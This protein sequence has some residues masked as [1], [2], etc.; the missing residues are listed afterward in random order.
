MKNRWIP[1]L[2]ALVLLLSAC[3]EEEGGAQAQ[4]LALTVT[5][6]EA[7]DTLDPARATARGGEM[8]LH[9]LYENLL[10]WEDGGDGWAVPAPGQAEE[11]TVETDY[12][13]NATY[14]F[15]LRRD[16]AWSDGQAVTASDF[17]NAWRRLADP[18]NDLPHRTL[19]EAVAG[20]D[21]VQETGD[22]SLLA[23]SAPDEHTFVVSLSGSCAWFLEELCAGAYT[24]PVRE[25]TAPDGSVTNGPYTAVQFDPA[26]VV[27]EP[28]EHYYDRSRVGPESLQFV[29]SQGAE[30]DY[31]SFLD[32]QCQL[33][34]LLP[35]GVLEQRREE[36]GWTPEPVTALTAVLFNTRQAP[37]DNAD[38][39]LAFRLVVDTQ[40]AADAAGDAALRAAA[41]VVPYGVADYGTRPEAAEPEP[42]EGLPDP[43]AASA[44]PEQ[45]PEQTC[46]DFRAHSL[47]KVTVPA[48]NDCQADCQEARR[49][50]AGAGYPNGEGFPAVEY[51]YVDSDEGAAAAAALCAMWRQELGVTVTAR[52]LAREELDARLA[53]AKAADGPVE[54]D[55]ADEADGADGADAPEDSG[56]EDAG[57]AGAPEAAPFAMAAVDLSA[58]YSDAGALLGR[59]HSASPNN[60]SGYRSDAFDI[61]LSSAA[62]AVSA[63]VRDAYLHDAEAILLEEAPVIP[64]WCRGG[65]SLLAEGL[66]GLFRQ[67]D[68]VY[69]LF[70]VTAEGAPPQK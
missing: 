60:F 26:R 47:E 36:G 68:G 12:A 22:A 11:Y 21:E 6:G 51:L 52:G 14:T 63:E 49:L 18:A 64:L 27:L 8:I 46:W 24:M 32:G 69:F 23:V 9:H 28:N 65:G 43:N 38:V 66:G 44:A 33:L 2:L 67:P 56:G 70:S 57:E 62:A 54:A 15:T 39:R 34:T 37:F 29:Q 3:G 4:P 41:G 61:L 10:R 42:D 20:Y 53:A 19:L 45:E 7:Q 5:V 17:V 35:E 50:L 40:A 48:E 55:E 30:A 59:W 31:Q 16:A 25:G 13:G 1:L 58:P